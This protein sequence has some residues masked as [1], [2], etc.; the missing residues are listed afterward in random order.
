MRGVAENVRTERTGKFRTSQRASNICR[1][2]CCMNNLQ[3]V[4]FILI[5]LLFFN[6]WDATVPR[7]EPTYFLHEQEVG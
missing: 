2:F 7:V 5:Y 4:N 1:V 6:K 3:L